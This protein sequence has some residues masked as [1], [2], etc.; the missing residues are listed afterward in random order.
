M[1]G[2]T[3]YVITLLLSDM[4]DGGHA[5]VVASMGNV[6]SLLLIWSSKLG[7]LGRQSLGQRLRL[8]G[9]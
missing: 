3:V 8:R 2:V 4:D 6:A 1:V 7:R 9:R 5:S